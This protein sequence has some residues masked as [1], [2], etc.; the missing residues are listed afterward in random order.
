MQLVDYIK[1]SGENVKPFD[2]IKKYVA[3]GD[4]I[5]NKIVSSIDVTYNAKPSRAN[6][7][8]EIGDILFA[9]MKN[10]I[11]V[12]MIDDM[13]CQYIYSTGFYCVRPDIDK[14]NPKFLYYYLLSDS[15]NLQ[16]DNYSS[17]A[18]M[19][20]LNDN[21]LKKISVS[22]PTLD[23]QSKIVNK[24]DNLFS[25]KDNIINSIE[26]LDLYQKS[27]FYETFG[28]PLL[29]EKSL[30]VLNVEECC[31]KITDGSHFSPKGEN[32]GYPMLS[33]KDMRKSDFDF[34][35]CKYIDEETFDVL[36]KQ[37]CVP[38]QD[39]LLISKDGSYF[40]YG[41]ICKE[42]RDI[43]LL[44]SIAILRPNT[45][46]VLPEY[47]RMYLMSDEVVDLVSKNYVTGTALK[48]VILKGVKKIPVMVPNIELQK[49][50][51]DKYNKIEIA[52][53]YMEDNKKDI[54]D[55]IKSYNISFFA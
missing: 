16:K 6:V 41:F 46:I 3:T 7:K 52:I 8:A 26:E 32:C 30:N 36:K 43:A 48:R 47:L 2:G 10:T 1:K 14:L 23:E 39:D 4:I 33:V 15:F 55:L 40:A 31:E 49:D 35:D 42:Y 28:T 24:L 20:A 21:G 11:K 25:V 19:K 27:V 50:Y 18:T 5:E 22:F 12:I 51:A 45:S 44:S 34:S 29:N 9:K 13:N 53:K 37:G 54:A 17:G 38:Q